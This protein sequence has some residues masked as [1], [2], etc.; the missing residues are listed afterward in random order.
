MTLP[1]PC[2][3]A[4]SN[5]ELSISLLEKMQNC[6]CVY[7]LKFEK[8]V[9]Y[10]GQ[11]INLLRRITEH[12]N[13]RDKVFDEISY[14]EVEKEN[15]DYT[16]SKYI[17]LFNPI[18]NRLIP[19]CGIE[20]GNKNSINKRNCARCGNPYEGAL[21]GRYCGNSCK[22]KAYRERKQYGNAQE[23]KELRTC[24]R[25]GVQFI[26]AL[27]GRYHSAACKQAA[28]RERKNI[29]KKEVRYA[30]HP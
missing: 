20:K 21:H 5:F 22:Q 29:S 12:L 16:E 19:K 27:H 11:T 2:K 30:I 24:A 15:L 28:Y 13:Q 3:N 25:C 14:I 23:S 9:V 8:E 1:D 6:T 26:G 4:I 10:V 17:V 18:F 7:F